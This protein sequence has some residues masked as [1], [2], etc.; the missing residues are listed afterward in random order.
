MNR[1][2][3][4]QLRPPRTNDDRPARAPRPRPQGPSG[5]VPNIQQVIPGAGVSI[6]LKADQPTGREVQGVVQDLLTRGNHPRGIKVRLQDGRVGRVQRMAAAGTAPS[7]TD[8]PPAGTTS[9]QPAARTNRILRMETDVRLY[10][11]E[12]PSAPPARSF[13]DYF[14]AELSTPTAPIPENVSSATAKCPICGTFEGDEIAV[15]RHVEEHLT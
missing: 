11:E 14:P 6:V 8:V 13:A 10:E 2:R 7:T 3:N 15:S 1:P 12:F 5:N 4:H 9:Q